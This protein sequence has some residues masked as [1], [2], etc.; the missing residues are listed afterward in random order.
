M[1]Q[2]NCRVSVDCTT[3]IFESGVCFGW[4]YPSIASLPPFKDFMNPKKAIVIL[5]GSF[6]RY[7]A[8]VVL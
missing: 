6:P 4:I 3:R 8:N 7:S 1:L 5:A 2:F